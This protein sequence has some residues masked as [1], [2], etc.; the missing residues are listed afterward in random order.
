MPLRVLPSGKPGLIA[1]GSDNL[2]LETSLGLE[3]DVQLVITR[4][5]S[6]GA[7]VEV[8]GPKF[9]YSAL[10]RESREFRSRWSVTAVCLGVA[11]G[12]VGSDVDLLATGDFDVLEEMY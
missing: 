10:L 6:R 2:N 7:G 1:R 11:D 8:T 12:A 5:I 4:P 3:A 9:E